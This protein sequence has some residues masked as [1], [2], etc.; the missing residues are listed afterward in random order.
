MIEFL[1]LIGRIIAGAFFL[2]NAYKHFTGVEGMAGYAGSQGVPAPRLAVVG[3][4][5]LLLVGG[6]SLITGILPVVG[7]VAL[8][9][10]LLPVSL[11]M[12]PFWKKDDPQARMNERVNFTKNLSLLGLA[13]VALAIPLPWPLSITLF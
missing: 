2:W 9:L 7:I 13:L 10:F 11:V 3:S 4:G 8:A 12:H 6:L 1:F 5:V